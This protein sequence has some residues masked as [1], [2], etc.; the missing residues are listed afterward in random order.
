MNT[1]IKKINE[2]EFHEHIAE[3]I[4]NPEKFSQRDSRPGSDFPFGTILPYYVPPNTYI[5]LPVGWVLAAGQK[6]PFKG[7]FKGYNVPDLTTGTFLVGGIYEHGKSGGSNTISKS[8]DHHHT[9]TII[10]N[11]RARRAPEGYQAA[12]SDCK[13]S[14]LN[15]S[16]EGSHDHGGD[17]RPKWFGVVYIIRVSNDY[18]C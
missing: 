3:V 11:R 15:T 6:I 17:N 18:S 2:G 13:I 12:G 8:D 10:K 4:E 5:Q 16:S 1:E 7:P 9:Y 14:T